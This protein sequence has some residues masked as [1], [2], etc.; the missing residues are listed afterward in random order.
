MVSLGITSPLL[1][2]QVGFYEYENIFSIYPRGVSAQL[3]CKK[4]LEEL[5]G[6]GSSSQ[7]QVGMASGSSAGGTKV[8]T[9]S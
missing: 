5:A 4:S 2:Y 8:P 6:D 3:M 7:R 1:Q 9:L